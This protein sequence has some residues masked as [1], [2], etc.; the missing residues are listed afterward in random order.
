MSASSMQ[1]Y[2]GMEAD[3]PAELMVVWAFS[4]YEQPARAFRWA[5]SRQ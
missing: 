2:Y 3:M 1:L 5:C 4:F